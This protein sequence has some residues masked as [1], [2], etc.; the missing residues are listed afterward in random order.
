MEKK[1]EGLSMI[2]AMGL[3]S[4]KNQNKKIIHN[5]NNQIKIQKIIQNMTSQII[6]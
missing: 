1:V 5:N 6:K 2:Y 4:T 3:S